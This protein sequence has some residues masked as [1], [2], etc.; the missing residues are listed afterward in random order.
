MGKN[1]VGRQ[2]RPIS[3]KQVLVF[4]E[5]IKLSNV[6]QFNASNKGV[7]CRLHSRLVQYFVYLNWMIYRMYQHSKGRIF[8]VLVMGQ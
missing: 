8:N 1:K 3:P 7:F 5:I 4:I 6:N 2:V